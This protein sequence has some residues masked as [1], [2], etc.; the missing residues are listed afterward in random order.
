MTHDELKALLP[1][2]AL[3]RL[4]PDEV[5]ALREHLAGCAECDAELREFEHTLSLL[6]LAVDGPATAERVTRKLE[7]RL[8]APAPVVVAPA[9][10][11]VRDREP[12]RVVEP[13]RRSGGKA[14]PRIAIAAAIVLAIYGVA[15]TSRMIDLRYAYDERGNKLA[16]LQNRFN[17]L[18]QEAKQSEQKIDALSKVLS[19]RVRLE[20]VLDA[21]DLQV[22][23]L[24][25]LGPAPQ[26]HAVVAISRSSSDAVLRVTGLEPP[27]TGKI[28]ELWWITKQKGPEP[29]GTFTTDTDQEV[30][31]KVDAPPAG[32]RV[33]ASA[34]TLEPAGG[35]PKPTG[36]MYLKGSPDH[37]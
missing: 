22:T 16:Y 37:E 8:A 5:E 33:M 17:A 25:P 34:V 14:G 10:T 30:I 20:H 29:A 12:A 2:A 1:L 24:G 11:P 3:E 18:E 31:A 7:A 32:E 6:A 15:I 23:R 9:P 21:P 35:V 28:Y 13:A 4:D 19:D 27:P 26:A 36:A